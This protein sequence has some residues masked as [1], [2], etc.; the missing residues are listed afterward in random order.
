MPRIPIYNSR[1]SAP[2]PI[3]RLG[4]D[5]A[6][7]GKAL[8]RLGGAVAGF[9]EALAKRAEPEDD[10]AKEAA[11]EAAIAAAAGI[12]PGAVGA[13]AKGA[14]KAKVKTKS[15]RR[16]VSGA[17]EAASAE[18]EGDDGKRTGAEKRNKAA[19]KP[20]SAQ[21]FD[22]EATAAQGVRLG[23]MAKTMTLSEVEVG[24]LAARTALV[25]GAGQAGDPETVKQ[26]QIASLDKARGKAVS[27]IRDPAL[28]GEA[29]A[30]YQDQSTVMAARLDLKTNALRLAG[31]NGRFDAMLER[32]VSIVRQDRA[33]LAPAFKAG[34]EAIDALTEAADVDED[35]RDAMKLGFSK[36]LHE[37][38]VE[39]VI[40]ARPALALASLQSGELDGRL[41]NDA[42]LIGRL[43]RKAERAADAA[44]AREKRAARGRRGLFALRKAEHLDSV[45]KTGTGDP[46]IPTLAAQLLDPV[47]QAAFREEAE[48][49]DAHNA[50]R[51]A[52]AFMT[53]EEI[54]ADIAQKA[55]GGGP[56][57]TDERAR[58]HQTR[59]VARDEILAERKQ[60]TAGWAM[61]DETV[62]A[63]FAAAEEAAAAA[64]SPESGLAEAEQ[65]DRAF[66]RALA[67]RT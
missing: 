60:D 21:G 24:A 35:H 29:D 8:R 61:R 59:T 7:P 33:M 32:L 52:Y 31:L 14:V 26:V 17:A 46:E 11:V 15:H 57:D 49:A 47:E 58:G 51:D 65:A 67:L 28:R 2:G 48:D 42:V 16:S 30:I 25:A 22:P 19:S 43:V 5:L 40:E 44:T 41:G 27:A 39:S 23:N 1:V 55:P 64:E 38:L 3:P 34:L 54:D 13:V 50:A 36:L 66:R 63:A 56:R 4:D 53:V 6:A 45:C 9:G 62:A 12:A 20:D 18:K 37:G 10:T